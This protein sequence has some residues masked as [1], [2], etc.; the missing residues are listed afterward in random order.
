MKGD[1]EKEALKKQI[2]ALD[3][4]NGGN[5]GTDGLGIWWGVI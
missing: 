3:E 4:K 2:R 1:V 5:D